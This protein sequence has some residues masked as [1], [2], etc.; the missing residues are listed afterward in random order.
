MWFKQLTP[1]RLSQLPETR[2]LDESLGNH[3]FTKTQGLDW[4]TEGF[5]YPQPFTDRAVFETNGS[6][7]VSLKREEKVL[8]GAA[9]KLKLD[10]K[11]EKIQTAE[12]RKVGR[13]EKAE[14]RQSIIDDLLPKALTKSS[15]T[16]G[17]LTNGW[18]WVD[19]ANSRKAQNLLSHLHRAVGGLRVLHPT[20]KS[21]PMYLMTE[22]IL[23]KEAKGRFKLGEHATLSDD[24]ELVRISNKRLESDEVVYLVEK[25]LAVIKLHLIWDG[26]ISFVLNENAA[27]YLTNIQWLDMLVK[28]SE[29]NADDAYSKA[30]AEQT[31]MTAALNDMLTELVDLLGGWQD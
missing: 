27:M 4:F 22:W 20:C 19:T 9:I 28:E 18:L 6:L 21:R 23:N 8:P 14:I 12:A 16:Y 7:L 3:W 25:G 11:V 29:D 5:T 13:K 24:V 30:I 15:H 31:I 17:L 10:E 1:F 2:Q 26:K